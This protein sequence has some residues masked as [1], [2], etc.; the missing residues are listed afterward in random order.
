MCRI[1]KQFAVAMMGTLLGFSGAGGCDMTGL[2]SL[3]TLMDTLSSWESDYGY[4]DSYDYGGNNL[5]WDL[6][7]VKSG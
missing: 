3:S 5:S 2:S 7:D 4:Y 6:L 1:R